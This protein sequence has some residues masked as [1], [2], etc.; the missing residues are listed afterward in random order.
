MGWNK[1][2]QYKK[3]KVYLSQ[4]QFQ[5]CPHCGSV[6]VFSIKEDLSG[7]ELVCSSRCAGEK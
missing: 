6:M 3:G 5:A 1:M 7:K 4:S 2:R